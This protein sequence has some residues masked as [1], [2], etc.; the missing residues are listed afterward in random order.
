MIA[1]TDQ[2]DL[3]AWLAGRLVALAPSLKPLAPKDQ[4]RLRQEASRL[5]T[6]APREELKRLIALMASHMGAIPLRWGGSVSPQDLPLIGLTEQ[7]EI[8]LVL[9]VHADGSWLIETPQTTRVLSDLPNGC[10]LG[11]LSPQ[12]DRSDHESAPISAARM[13]RRALASH[14]GLIA[15][16]A[17][18]TVFMNIFALLTSLY[19]MQ[20]YDRVLPT[21]GL[22]TL[23][24][25]TLGVGLGIGME[26]IGKFTRTYILDHAIRAVDS[27]LSFKIFERLLNI[28]MDQFPASVGT[29]AAQ[30]RSY[31]QIRSFAASA[32]LYVLVDAPFA[33]LFILIIVMLAGPAV[34]TVPLVFFGL[35]LALGLAYRRRM[36]RHA[37]DGMAAANRKLGLL[38]ETVEG[39]DTV[40]A[41]G[42]GW[43]L[44]S[45][46]NQLTHICIREDMGLRHLGESASYLTGCLQ[47]IGYVLLVAVGA[48]L[49]VTTRDITSGAIIA[50]SILSGRVLSPAAM[51]PT[52]LLQ[53][54]HASSAMDSLQRIFQ[55]ELDN[56]GIAR[57]IVPS[58]SAIGL[59]LKEVRHSYDPK[60]GHFALSIDELDIRPGD[61]VGI[62]GTVGSGKSTLLKMISGMYRPTEGRVLMGG[63][64]MQHISRPHLSQTVGYLPQSPRLFAGTLRENLLGGLIGKTDAQIIAI[65]EKT[66]L[67]DLVANHPKGWELPIHEGGHGLSGGQ[68]QL[69]A[70]TR[71]LVANPGI[72]LLDEPTASM[73]DTLER[74]IKNLLRD[75]LQPEQTLV[76]VTHKPSMLDLVDRLVVL[77]AGGVAM[78]GPTNLVLEQLNKGIRLAPLSPTS[79]TQ[80][81]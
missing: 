65:A 18:A 57:P 6:P 60:G 4:E 28:R 79:Q 34:A 5:P 48:Y 1:S 30:L 67:A 25:L 62:L 71:M 36:Q 37:K 12:D 40:K 52:M 81:A 42:S 70:L 35:S 51:L 63:V 61:K 7:G 72:W 59:Q 15:Q 78:H 80:R 19:S 66:G 58:P 24:V 47:Q 74:R 41:N 17:L 20:V 43:Q 73:D 3:F 75:T 68:R 27:E 45:R 23:Y 10:Q 38:V 13:I 76:L 9:A 55:L 21:Q 33:I 49:A 64:D 69:L 53:W 11:A 26:L 22:A 8:M 31:E 54:A 16:A 56:Q 44:L 39:A 50:C 14:M 46:W 32:S 29:L 77:G 2:A